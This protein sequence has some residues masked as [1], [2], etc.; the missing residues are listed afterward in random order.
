MTK[1]R[2]VEQAALKCLYLV[3]RSLDPTGA[4]RTRWTMRWKPVL[5]AFALTFSDRSQ[6][7]K[8]TYQVAGTSDGGPSALAEKD[9]QAWGEVEV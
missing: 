3:T 2:G 4:G 7:L 6:P 8:P 9:P 5:N 1:H